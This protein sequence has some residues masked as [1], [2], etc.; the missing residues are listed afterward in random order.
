MIEHDLPLSA[1]AD[2]EVEAIDAARSCALHVR[3]LRGPTERRTARPQLRL[4][5]PHSWRRHISSLRDGHD[6]KIERVIASKRVVI[7]EVQSEQTTHTV[8]VLLDQRTG[9]IV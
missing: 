8:D 9:A 2:G 4:Q 7:L 5:D 6:P 3:I 1:S